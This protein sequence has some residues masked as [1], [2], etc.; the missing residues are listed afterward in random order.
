M[1]KKH[2]KPKS[3]Q[4]AVAPILTDA[5]LRHDYQRACRLAET[6]QHAQARRLYEM[7]AKAVSE[8]SLK[9]LITNDLAALDLLGGDAVAARSG[10]QAALA[11]DACCEPARNNLAL[12]EADLAEAGTTR[13]EPPRAVVGE[14]G[15]AIRVALLSFLF[16]WPSTGGG[17]VHSYEL[18]L[19]LARAGYD[20]RHFYVRY[21]PW[22]IG[23]VPDALPYAAEA[24]T[25]AESDWHA[26]AIQTRFRKAVQDFDPGH[27]IV[28]DSW[29][30]KPLLA[31]AVAAYPYLLRFQASECLCPLNNLRLLPEAGN[32]FRQC[33]LHQLATPK[34]C[35]A[36]LRQRGQWSGSLHRAERAL[37]GVG[38]HEYYDRLVR[39]V[40]QAEACLVVNPHA[41]ALLAP[42]ARRV[43]VVTAGMDPARF[44]WPWPGD[45]EQHPS[46]PKMRLLFAGL[47]GEPIKGFDVLCQACARLWERRQDFELT[48]TD[49]P[50]QVAPEPFAR[51]IGWQS[52]ADLPHYLHEADI[53]VVPTIAQEA[54]GRTAVEAMAAGRPV[55]ASRLGGLPF[56]VQDGLTGLLCEPADPE[57]L[58]TKIERLLDDQDLRQQLGGAGRKR[59]EEHYSWPVI[60]ERHYQPLLG[61]PQRAPS[62]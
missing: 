49:E 13:R 22:Q 5:S 18:A 55:V 46:P 61:V 33:H 56:T 45:K 53:C 24:L 17:N 27:V 8:V 15:G 36:C 32:S 38:T 23:N 54:L 9:A 35:Y 11:L 29:N 31:E 12:L 7:L 62:K 25:F 48:V 14:H 52:Q 2:R 39:V 60:I 51:Y 34:E 20:V 26:P 6:G 30:F 50:P 21:E 4:R 59:F 41:E 19:F 28:T 10:F 44:P 43:R 37:S 42:F 16:N 57:D 3:T 47:V 1:R 58:A 40:E